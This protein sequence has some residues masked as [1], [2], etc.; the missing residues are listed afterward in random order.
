MFTG[1]IL[2]GLVLAG[3][4]ILWGVNIYSAGSVDLPYK[5]REGFLAYHDN[6]IQG[7]PALLVGLGLILMGVAVHCEGYWTHFERTRRFARRVGTAVMWPGLISLCVGVGIAVVDW[8][9]GK[10]SGSPNVNP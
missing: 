5:Y 6:V 4:L 10:P 1:Y 7:F 2:R 3:L 8:L 9:N